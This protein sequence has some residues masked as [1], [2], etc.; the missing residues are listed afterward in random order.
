MLKKKLKGGE[1]KPAEATDKDAEKRL[2]KEKEK[3]AEALKKQKKDNE[4]KRKAAGGVPTALAKKVTELG[5]DPL[6]NEYL[7]KL[8]DFKSDEKFQTLTDWSEVP[9]EEMYE[10]LTG[11][12][13]NQNQDLALA[14]QNYLGDNTKAKEAWMCM[15]SLED[16]W[17]KWEDMKYEDFM[18]LFTNEVM[19]KVKNTDLNDK[20]ALQKC[21][22]KYKDLKVKEAWAL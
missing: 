9:P 15:K 17:K 4:K 13:A 1:K 7:L 3:D 10:K 16:L 5:R 14:F 22:T 21:H 2:K 20:K 6:R 12:Q 19:S 18:K 8:E 11:D